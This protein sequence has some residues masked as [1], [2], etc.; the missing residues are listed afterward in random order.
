[1][2]LPAALAY[3]A[4]KFLLVTSAVALHERTPL[5][6]TLRAALPYQAFVNLVLLATAPL[7]AVVMSVHSALLVLLFAFPLAA[8]YVNAAHVGAARAPGPS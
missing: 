8:I 4:V 1:M 7:V 3:F 6:K 2:V 5:V